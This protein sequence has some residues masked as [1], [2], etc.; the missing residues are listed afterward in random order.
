MIDF[1]KVYEGWRNKIIPPSHLKN[2]IELT[3][4]QRMKECHTCE[5]HSD[6]RKKVDA[7]YK[8]IRPDI[9]CTSCGCTLSAKT[10]CLSCRCPLNKWMEVLTGDQEEEIKKE[11]YE[12]Q[13]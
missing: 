5:H 7:S 12:Q 6:N 4:I 8:T 11:I 3:S 1:S 10:S 2:L 9:H 13:S